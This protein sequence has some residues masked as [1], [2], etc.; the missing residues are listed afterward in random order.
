MIDLHSHILPGIDDGAKDVETSLQMARAAVANGVKV[1]ACTPHILPGVWQNTGPD[2]RKRVAAL[3]STLDEEGIPLRLV[4][5]ADVHITPSLVEGLRSGALL[6]LH[7]T[8]YVLIE[9]PHHIAPPR[10]DTPLYA[11]L[12]AGYVPIFTHPERLTWIESH[13]DLMRR[14]ALSGVWM[15]IT[16]GSLTGG[17]GRRPKYWAERM[18]S[19]GLVHILAT[20]MHDVS[21]RPPVL[22]EGYDAARKLVGDEEAVRLVLT[23]PHGVIRNVPPGSI[24]LPESTVKGAQERH[25]KEQGERAADGQSFADR[26]L[27]FLAGS[28][29]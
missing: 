27:G 2:I 24:E 5:G 9:A 20:D 19:E 3:Q 11:L 17:F 15:Q 25:E 28:R 4:V 23:R 22:A 13:Y 16:A 26:L 8:R 14:L 18:L 12:A 10:L 29:R 6:S 7:D 1:L 21:R